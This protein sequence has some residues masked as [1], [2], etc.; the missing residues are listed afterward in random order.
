M[1]AKKISVSWSG[2]KDSSYMLW[3]ILSQPD[4]DVV[5][6]H[7]VIDAKTQRVGLHGVHKDLIVAQAQ[8]IGLPIRFIFLE[9]GNTNEKYEETI[10]KYYT[11]LKKRNIDCVAFG[12]IFLE[13]LKKYRDNLLTGFNL[14]GIYPLWGMNTKDLAKQFIKENFKSII[15]AA[16]A[17]K[18]PFEIAGRHYS[19]QLLSSFPESVDPCGENGEFHSFVYN[20]SIF[21]HPICIKKTGIIEKFYEFKDS[22]GKIQKSYFHFCDLQPGIP[23]LNF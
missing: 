9:S 15:C 17:D 22:S 21:N 23:L 16:D 13:D 2:G 20:G 8:S 14:E 3:S 19:T 5:E 12:D 18:F 4:F 7:T 6:L 1:R 11:D 10:K